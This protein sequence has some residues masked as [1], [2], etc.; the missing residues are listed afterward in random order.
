MREL[1][2][3]VVPVSCPG[4]GRPDETCCAA[5]AQ[6]LA[7]APR[8]VE[9]DAPRLDRLDGVPPLPVWALVA[10]TGH[11]RPLVVAWKDRGRT[12]LDGLLGHALRR[13][14]GHV[15]SS[16]GAS[17]RDPAG[18]GAAPEVLVVPAPSSA[19]AR[20]ARGREPVQVLARAVAR[21]LAD[22]GIR[23]RPVRVLDRRGRV[24]DQVGLGSRARGRNQAA[25][26]VVRR[27]ALARCAPEGR[28]LCLLVDDVLTTG[29]TLA[30]AERALEEAGCDIV[31]ALVVAATPSP[32]ALSSRGQTGPAQRCT[33]PG[34]GG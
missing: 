24:R 14:A 11:V 22:A 19:A 5:C 17:V 6:P 26:V 12:D 21:G 16:V 18:T 1:A 25:S 27:R 20:R 23:A 32:G 4:C 10:Y 29:A 8:R 13:A 3:L 15:G 2:R 7:R 33:G 31:G 9:A 30:A 28:P 34:D